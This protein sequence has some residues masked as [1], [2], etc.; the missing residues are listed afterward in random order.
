MQK[1]R[2]EER[3][4]D[5][6]EWRRPSLVHSREEKTREKKRKNFTAFLSTPRSDSLPR[7]FCASVF[8][9]LAVGESIAEE[10][11]NNQKE[12]KERERS[13][14]AESR[15]KRIRRRRRRGG[16]DKKVG[17]RRGKKRR[18]EERRKEGRRD[19]ERE[20]RERKKTRALSL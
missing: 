2:N 19:R 14:S 17:Q 15:R 16:K 18:S 1:K 5:S 7:L 9:Y 20:E 8:I 6:A 4:V 12:K 3:E 13:E 10:E 11:E